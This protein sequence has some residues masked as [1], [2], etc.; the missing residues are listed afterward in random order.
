MM[1]LLIFIITVS[2]T[3]LAQNSGDRCAP[4]DETSYSMIDL[5]GDADGTDQS[6]QQLLYADD[7]DSDEW[8]LE[9]GSGRRNAHISEIERLN[10]LRLL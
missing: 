7:T 5:V 10:D 3:L 8:V 9:H 1:S 2:A 6:E 4:G